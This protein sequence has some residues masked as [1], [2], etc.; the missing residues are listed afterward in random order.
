MRRARRPVIKRRIAAAIAGALIVFA[1]AVGAQ[2]SKLPDLKGRTIIAVTENAFLPLNFADPKTG[3]GIGWEYDAVNEIG[4]RL[5]A[6]NVWKLSS[7]DTLIQAIRD[8]QFAADTTLL[9]GAQAGDVDTVLTDAGPSKGFIFKKG[10]DLA[11]PFNGA[12][13]SMKAEGTL[14]KLTMKWFVEYKP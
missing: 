9:I 4:K 2:V 6:K 1:A 7:R 11:T 13:A 12:I 14:D 10:S 8:G 5:D 3:K